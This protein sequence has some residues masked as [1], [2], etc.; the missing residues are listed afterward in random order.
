[1]GKTILFCD[2]YAPGLKAAWEKQGFSVF[3]VI[4]GTDTMKLEEILSCFRD[5]RQKQ[6]VAFVFSWD[7]AP[8]IAE[9]CH[10]I[11]ICYISWVV[12]CPHVAL[13]AK[14]AR[15]PENRIFVF[16]YKLYEMLEQR[17]LG[18]IWYLPLSADVDSFEQCIQMAGEK[19][20]KEY[21]S[22]VSF[23]GNLYN[24]SAH[25][26]YDRIAYLPPYLK[27]YFDSLIMIQRKIW[28][29][30]LFEEAI[31]NQ[32]WD[33]LR[34]HVKWDL[35]DKYEDVYELSMINMLC[36]KVAQLDRQE[37]CN[38]LAAH[39]DFAL[40]TG[41]DTN[42]NPALR[43]RGKVDYLSQ[44]PL[45]FH[46]SKININ[47]TLRS[48][49]SG[50]PLRVMDVLACEGFLLTNY[51]SEIAEYFEDGRELVIY[52]NFEDMYEKIAYYLQHEEERKQIAHAGYE[53]VKE[54]FHYTRGI[55]KIVQ[56]L[57]MEI[58]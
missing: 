5:Y 48:I 17:G 50:I 3:E 39:F 13:W 32:A 25:S 8:D 54:Q 56:A 57:D 16:D 58:M 9:A 19:E 23:V 20:R 37:V 40:Y 34:Q 11:G 52:E 6:N 12:D 53:K 46:Y 55:E 4:K 24:D 27:G 42:F 1:M 51:Q 26:L 44:M 18:H 33:M 21:S 29:M 43:N 31:N 2:H 7:F 30:N 28:G 22:E 38:Y 14:S 41:G 47:I 49:T 45:V 15:Y 10:E 35:G 36:Q